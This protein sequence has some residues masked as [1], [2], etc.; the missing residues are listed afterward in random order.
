[1]LS[2]DESEDSMPLHDRP[3]EQLQHECLLR[4]DNLQLSGDKKVD[5]SSCDEI[6]RRASEQ[7]ANG[8]GKLKDTQVFETLISVSRPL[9]DKLRPSE[10]G[11]RAEE[12]QRLVVE[13][14]E[15]EF[16]SGNNSLFSSQF[17]VYQAHLQA[18]IINVSV[19]IQNLDQLHIDCQE[20]LRVFDRTRNLET[21]TS[22]CDDILRLAS[23]HDALAIGK[24]AEISLPLIERNCPRDLR[25][26]KEDLQN[27]V[28]IRL[29]YRFGDKSNPYHPSGFAAYRVFLNLIVRSV[30]WHIRRDDTQSNE[31]LDKL[32]EDTNFEPEQPSNSEQ[33][34]NR[35]RLDR[36]HE[37]LLERCRNSPD[38]YDKCQ[39][40]AEV[41]KL[42]FISDHNSQE[43]T[44]VLRSRRWM[45]WDRD[46]NIHRL[47]TVKDVYK[48]TERA[49]HYLAAH[50]EVKDM[51]G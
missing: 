10:L 16:S 35:L 50:P 47:I 26:K 4:L 44:E 51:F 34:E 42:R 21:N 23:G 5:T 1:M 13:Q 17:A 27:L 37:L 40:D 43:T 32:W 33:I 29:I 2:H 49:I 36:C 8:L 3:L 14:L 22:S 7:N 45:I 15:V 31:S 30:V 28:V 41:F 24:L 48:S 9:I 18:I 19:H 39:L 20:Q 11:W 6:L 25:D 12:L 38:N 46:Q